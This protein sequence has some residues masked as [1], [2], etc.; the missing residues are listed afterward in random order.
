MGK[1]CEASWSCRCH[2][3]RGKLRRWR[4]GRC[5]C[6]H[7]SREGK[8]CGRRC[9]WLIGWSHSWVLVSGFVDNMI[10]GDYTVIVVEKQYWHRR[11]LWIVSNSL[12]RGM[13]GPGA[14]EIQIH[15]KNCCLARFSVQ[16]NSHTALSHIDFEHIPKGLSGGWWNGY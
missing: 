15:T 8:T 3:G 16:W 12:V 5:G 2:R 13:Q 14:S 9:E 7:G 4:F 1:C 10:R 6:R 11:E